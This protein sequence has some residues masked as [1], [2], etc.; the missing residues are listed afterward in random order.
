MCSRPCA[1]LYKY[2]WRTDFTNFQH[3][4]RHF[5]GGNDKGLLIC[6]WPKGG[7]PANTIPYVDEVWT[8]VEYQV[9]AHMLYEGLMDE[10][11]AVVKGARE[12]YDGIPRAPIPRSPWN[13]IE[14]GGHYARAM[15]SWSLLLALSGF[16]YDGL[17]QTLRFQ[18]LETSTA[19][20]QVLLHRPGGLGQSEPDAAWRGAADRDK[21]R[22]R[23]AR[24]H[25]PASRG[26]PRGR[27]RK[28]CWATPPSPPI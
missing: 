11:F 28:S 27:R 13:E 4:W 20:V 12:R 6:T 17:T 21:S 1:R 7:R 15:S 23:A 16:H 2:N 18:P 3:N 9:A 22:L 8:G 26:A 24:R 10:G 14:C 19:H 5:A 25:A